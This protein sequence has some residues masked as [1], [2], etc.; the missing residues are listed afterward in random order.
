MYFLHI[1]VFR[2]YNH[3]LYNI[4]YKFKHL[5]TIFNENT[6]WHILRL[7]LYPV[8]HSCSSIHRHEQVSWSHIRVSCSSHFSWSS[9][10]LH[11]HWHSFALY[12]CEGLQSCR[13]V[14]NLF[15]NILFF[16]IVNF[17]FLNTLVLLWYNHIYISRVVQRWQFSFP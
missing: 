5:K 9:R 16:I 10:L 1:H 15:Y 7:N 14:L 2:I 8:V 3:K 12:T 4:L 13:L 17:F 6:Y 11:T